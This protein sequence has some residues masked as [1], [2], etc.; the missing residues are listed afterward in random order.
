[1]H[2]VSSV[3]CR[4]MCVCWCNALYTESVNLERE[5]TSG[6][7]CVESPRAAQGKPVVADDSS[8]AWSSLT[9]LNTRLEFNSGFRVGIPKRWANLSV[10]SIN[11]NTTRCV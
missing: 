5:D 4:N 8:H 3:Y 9:R 6:A 11:R 1:M 7:E 10:E 2:N